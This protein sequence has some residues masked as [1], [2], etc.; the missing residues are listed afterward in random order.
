MPHQRIGTPPPV[1]P[2][3]PQARR[4]AINWQH[5]YVTIQPRLLQARDISPRDLCPSC[6]AQ[7]LEHLHR[8]GRGARDLEHVVVAEGECSHGYVQR[9]RGRAVRDLGRDAL[10]HGPEEL[11]VGRGSDRPLAEL[12]RVFHALDGRVVIPLQAY[13][14]PCSVLEF[15]G[16]PF[17]DGLEE[18]GVHVGIDAASEGKQEV[19]EE[20][21]AHDAPGQRL[22]G[23]C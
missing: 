10:D 17:V 12:D 20:I 4:K 22:V 13:D 19:A 23:G 9:Q 5:Q 11:M 3:M 2:T 6:L 7:G 18:S 1:T 8:P 21:A 15:F 14:E 16:H